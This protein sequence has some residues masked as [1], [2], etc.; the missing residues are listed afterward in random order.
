[1]SKENYLTKLEFY[2]DTY[3]DVNSLRYI[4]R[5]L[6]AERLLLETLKAPQWRKNV[7]RTELRI[8]IIEIAIQ[9]KEYTAKGRERLELT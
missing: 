5:R 2:L 4:L 8:F 6:N 9:I 3:S 1:M 7:Y